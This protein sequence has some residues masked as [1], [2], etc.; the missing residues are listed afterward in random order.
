MMAPKANILGVRVS[1]INMEMALSTIDEWITRQDPHYV[2]VTGVHGIMESQRD[3]VLHRIHNAAGLV[4][5]DGMP[6]VWLSWLMGFRHVERVYGPDLML[7]VCEHSAKQGYRQF[8]YG[9]APGVAEKLA[10][11]LQS[12]FPGLQVSGFYAP[13]F[14]PL[15]PEEDQAVVEQ[16]NAAQ[17]DILWVG[18]ST[19]KQER[20]MAEHV[21]RLCAP[22]LIGVGAA[23]DFHAGI[24][25]QAPRWMQKGGLEWLFRLLTEPRRLWRRYLTNNPLFLW[26]VLLQVLGRGRGGRGYNFRGPG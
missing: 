20:W 5:P 25:K 19:P 4:T 26:L 9:G 3:G 1:A 10:A 13:P 21:G 7:A 23:F 2:C 6:L 22:V 17:P 8:F 16:I 11:R 15:T 14:R 18:I 24:K 12:R